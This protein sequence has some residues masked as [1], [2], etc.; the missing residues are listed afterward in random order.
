MR[1]PS[2]PLLSKLIQDFVVAEHGG[3]QFPPRRSPPR[4]HFAQCQADYNGVVICEC[5]RQKVNARYSRRYIAR[6][7]YSV[8]AACARSNVYR[9]VWSDLA[10]T[11]R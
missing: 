5:I 7:V 6:Y 3:V 1:L 9:L 4:I 8:N 2:R 11:Y 10:S